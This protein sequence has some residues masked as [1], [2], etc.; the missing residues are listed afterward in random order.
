MI[1]LVVVFQQP[2]K[3]EYDSDKLQSATSQLKTMLTSPSLH[4]RLAD[5]PKT[6][7]SFGSILKN[8]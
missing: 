5:G 1:Y 4:L 7:S 2:V 6:D 8:Q 3:N